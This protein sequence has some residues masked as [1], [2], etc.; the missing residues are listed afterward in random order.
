MAMQQQLDLYQQMFYVPQ[1]RCD[2]LACLFFLMSRVK[3][4]EKAK[5]TVER[6]TLTLFGYGQPREEYLML[7]LFQHAISEEVRSAPTIADVIESHPLFLSIALHAREMRCGVS[8]GK[9][10]DETFE[11]TFFDPHARAEYIRHLQ[12]LHHLTEQFV[13]AMFGSVRQM[14]YSISSIVRE[15]LAAAKL[16]D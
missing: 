14:P 15:L 1:A 9:P 16:L 4:A 7:K 10:I 5:R 12:M 6:V 13:N 11:G 8:S 3:L 2:Y